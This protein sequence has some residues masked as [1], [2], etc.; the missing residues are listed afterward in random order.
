MIG[1]HL[2]RQRV[3]VDAPASP[4][5]VEVGRPRPSAPTRAF[6]R[7]ALCFLGM[8]LTL[9]IVWEGVKFL[10][11]DPWRLA[12]DE[13]APLNLHFTPPFSFGFAS[14]LNMPHL[15]DIAAAF[16]KPAR[17]H[18]PLLVSVLAE[19][20][21]FTMREAVAGFAIGALLGLL[22]GTVCAHSSLLERGLMPY[23]VASQTVPILAIAPMVV[24]WL[25]A[26]WWSVAIIAAYLAFFPVTI[27][28]LRGLQAADPGSLA[29]MHS[30]AASRWATLWKLRLP[31]ALP[32]IF[33]ALKIAA[34]T[35]VVGAIIGEL[36]SGISDGLGGA[37]L[38]FNQY[39]ISGPAKL[40][41]TIVMTALVGLLFFV[42]I[43][44]SEYLLLAKGGMRTEGNYASTRRH[45]DPP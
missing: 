14:D 8:F 18:G 13:G 32:Y 31:T 37:I 44:L 36:P 2:K 34:T 33:T 40:W 42:A 30:Y 11:G 29:L 26:G 43:A 21:L 1:S 6:S 3:V 5:A 45:A 15:W 7:Q 12:V 16:V 23:V 27:N 39:Y 35:S 25:Q 20:A 19:A 17:R 22:L 24:V 28:T 38:N 9:A 41:A 4:H 10:G